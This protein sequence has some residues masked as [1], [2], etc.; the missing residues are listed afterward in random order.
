MASFIHQKYLS[1]RIGTWVIMVKKSDW[2]FLLLGTIKNI[3][4]AAKR[5]LEGIFGI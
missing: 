5:S 3:W 2:S 1:F 4:I